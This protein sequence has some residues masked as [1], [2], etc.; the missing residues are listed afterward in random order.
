MDLEG[1]EQL[2]RARKHEHEHRAQALVRHEA[3]ERVARRGAPQRQHGTSSPAAAHAMDDGSAARLLSTG[4]Q[5]VS[6]R[7]R[8]SCALRAGRAC[9][10]ASHG[11]HSTGLPA[12]LNIQC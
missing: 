8:A 3:R 6:R 4:L 1:N 2:Q 9:T 7:Q 10:Y 12:V 11:R 5:R